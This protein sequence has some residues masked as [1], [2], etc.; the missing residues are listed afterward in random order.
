MNE[1]MDAL[2]GSDFEDDSEDDF[3]GYLDLDEC[4]LED[5]QREEEI[6]RERQMLDVEEGVGAEVDMEDVDRLDTVPEYTL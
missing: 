2:D 5:E 4:R 3:D 6:E 1:V